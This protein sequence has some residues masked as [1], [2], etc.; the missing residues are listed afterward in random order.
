MADDINV[1]GGGNIDRNIDGNRDGNRDVAFRHNKYATQKTFSVASLNAS[2]LN[3]T[4]Q[5]L[6]KLLINEIRRTTYMVY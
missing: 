6:Y 4:L 3:K 2:M 1:E 5:A